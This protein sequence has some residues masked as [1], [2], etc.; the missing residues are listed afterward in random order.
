MDLY[1][2]IKKRITNLT[3]QKNAG[4]K[5]LDLFTG[6]YRILLLAAVAILKSK[7]AYLEKDF[8]AAV[9][10]VLYSFGLRFFEKLDLTKK[11]AQ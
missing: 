8:L 11:N 9:G 6:R 2:H 7:I 4:E 1:Y 3:S 5:A 10:W